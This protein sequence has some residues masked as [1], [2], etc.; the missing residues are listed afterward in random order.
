MGS[1]QVPIEA[2]GEETHALVVGSTTEN[3]SDDGRLL[4]SGGETDNGDSGKDGEN[5]LGEDL[6]QEDASENGPEDLRSLGADTTIEVEGLESVGGRKLA[7]PET[8]RSVNTDLLEDTGE[9]VSKKLRTEQCENGDT[10]V[11]LVV[12]EQVLD[13]D[14]LD[15]DGRRSSGG[16]HDENSGVL[17]DVERSRIDPFEDTSRR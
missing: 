14:D 11:H 12:V 4:V 1:D 13:R 3:V 15:S 17:L 8:D 16:S 7:G 10:T 2:P 5:P 9:T 6:V